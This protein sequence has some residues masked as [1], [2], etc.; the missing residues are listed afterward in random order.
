MTNNGIGVASLNWE[1]RF[2]EVTAF[3]ALDATGSGTLEQMTQAVLDAARDG[4]DV[5]SMS[6]GSVAP[7]PPKP[8]VDAIRFAQRRGAIV[9][10][11]AGNSNE[12]AATHFPSNI[13]GVIAVAALD[14]QLR[15][16]KFSNTIG[17]LARPIAAPGVDILSLKAG[18][19]YKPLSGTSMA[20]PVV[21]GLLGVMR[22]LDPALSAE[23][24][25]RIL[26]DTGTTVDETADVGRLINAEAALQAVMQRGS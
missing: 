12:D 10:A 1:G 17:S 9:M 8:I 21:A 14:Q 7:F 16:A 26:H 18:G 6:L 15:K 20:T 19:G 5:I 23:D 13:D 2:V 25:Y 3:A 4:A 22:S 11:S 24:A